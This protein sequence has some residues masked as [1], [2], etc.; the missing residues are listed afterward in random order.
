MAGVA[1]LFVPLSQSMALA[2]A[3]VM[4][5][6]AIY[7]GRDYRLYVEELLA[8]TSIFKFLA[9][10]APAWQFFIISTVML[11]IGIGLSDW[12]T[13]VQ[14]KMLLIGALTLDLHTLFL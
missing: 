5:G 6:T 11:G 8:R 2:I 4:L 7:L 14:I 12:E 1:L 9:M 3:G 10:T 13:F